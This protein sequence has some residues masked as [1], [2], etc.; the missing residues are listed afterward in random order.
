[1]VSPA[2]TSDHDR[3]ARRELVL[4]AGDRVVSVQCRSGALVDSLEVVTAAGKVLRVGGTGGGDT[5]KVS[6]LHVVLF[7]HVGVATLTFISAHDTNRWTSPQG[8]S[9]ADSS[10]VSFR[11]LSF[12]EDANYL[13]CVFSL[14]HRHRWSSAQSGRGAA[15]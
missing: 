2:C 3:P 12:A 14:G 8:W 9:C 11:T 5:C 15:K 13:L 4:E 1:V 7:K 10:A 6:A